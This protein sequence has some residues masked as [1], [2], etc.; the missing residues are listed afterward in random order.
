[1][2]PLEAIRAEMGRGLALK[3]AEKSTA[4]QTKTLNLGKAMP[5]QKSGAAAK[6]EGASRVPNNDLD[7]DAFLRLLVL[8]MQHQ[9]PMEPVTNTDMLA[10]LAQ[11][12]AL[13]QM[14]T[15]NESFQ[16]L[17]GNIDQLN[18]ITAGTLLGSQ[19]QG[20]DMEGELVEGTVDRILM[21]NSMVYLE[22]DGRLVSMAG[23]LS[24]ENSTEPALPGA[25]S[26]ENTAENTEEV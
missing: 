14:N 9:D 5:I 24:I 17:S 11:F 21:D 2:N 16:F 20:V 10:Q 8:Q 1:M 6:A 7:R 19:I 22:V 26:D 12:S 13:E 18:F 25:T 23:V 3:L 4:L 15:L